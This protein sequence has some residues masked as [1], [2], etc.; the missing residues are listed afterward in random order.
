MCLVSKNIK[1]CIYIFTNKHLLYCD[2]CYGICNSIENYILY[3]G[4]IYTCKNCCILVKLNKPII[5][6]NIC[7]QYTTLFLSQD[8]NGIIDNLCNDCCDI[9]CIYNIWRKN[10]PI[11]NSEDVVYNFEDTEETKNFFEQNFKVLPLSTIKCLVLCFRLG[12]LDN[13]ELKKLIKIK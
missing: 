13:Y 3:Y 2:L 5:K 9:K 6:C 12:Y 8:D 10:Y 11:Y 1:K 7:N 4:D